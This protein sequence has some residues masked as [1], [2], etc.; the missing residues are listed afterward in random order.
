MTNLNA[1]LQMGTVI[2]IAKALAK[3]QIV[4]GVVLQPGVVDLQ[5]D[6]IG[7]EAIEEACHA[8]LSKYNEETKLG[9]QHK[10]FPQ[11]LLLVECYIAPV[12]FDLGTVHVLAGS[13]VIAVHVVPADLWAKVEK[14]ELGGF[15]IHGTAKAA[16][17][18][19]PPQA[20][21]A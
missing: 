12:D 8:F 5:G 6:V 17:V 19:Q 11:G 16:K 15:S 7:P 20:Q 1:A 2:P 14:G 9:I 13:W 21:A 18:L 10:S 4:Y 3:K